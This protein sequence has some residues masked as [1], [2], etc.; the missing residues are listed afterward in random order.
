LALVGE[1]VQE[2]EER[3]GLYEQEEVAV[4]EVVFKTKLS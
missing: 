4:V 3:L 1:A 2:D